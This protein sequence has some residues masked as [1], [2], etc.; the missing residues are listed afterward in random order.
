[1]KIN[2]IARHFDLDDNIRSYAEKKL[3]KIE[4][5]YD[6]IVEAQMILSAEKHRR[7]AEVTLA[8]KGVR[9]YAEEQTEN[10]F[11]SIDGV[12]EKID[13]QVRRYKEKIKDKKRYPKL[14]AT[15]LVNDNDVDDE[16]EVEESG[17]PE[18]IKVHKFAPKPITVQEAVAQIAASGRTFLMFSNSQTD[19]V[20]VVYRRK[21]GNYGWIEPDFE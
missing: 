5:Y 10:M 14:A 7:I 11:A 19:E 17:E 12:M 15:E 8:A 20:N 21:D 1:M 13:T 18:I 2:I 16:L 9:F 6:R 4:T 3:R